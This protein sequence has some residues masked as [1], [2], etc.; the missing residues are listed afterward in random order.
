V[1]IFETFLVFAGKN[2][3]KLKVRTF[4]KQK[5]AVSVRNIPVFDRK[6]RSF[7]ARSRGCRPQYSD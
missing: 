1:A 4:A 5:L 7:F 6:K 2:Q 3:K